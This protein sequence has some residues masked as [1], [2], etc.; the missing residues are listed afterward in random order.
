MRTELLDYDLPEELIAQEPLPERSASRMMVLYRAERRWEHRSFR[1]L[2]GIL[3]QGDCLVLNDTRV[4]PARLL[5]RRQSGGRVEVLLLKPVG[6]LRWQVLARP[7]RRLREGEQIRFSDELSGRVTAVADGGVREIQFECVGRFD[8]IL[9]R[10][11]QPPLPPYIRRPPRHEDR[12]RYQ[13]VYAA[14]PG[15]VAAPTAG[16]HFD[17]HILHELRKHGVMVTT[18]TLHVGLGTFRPISTEL[19]EEHVMHAE[20]YSVPPASADAI[21]R[22]RAAGARV[23]AVGTTVVRTLETVADHSGHISPG[24]GE[25]DLFIYPGY[26]FKAIDAMLTNFHLPRSSLLAMVAAFAGRQFILDAYREAVRLRYRFYSYG[27]CMLIL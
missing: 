21:N 7:A 26:R 14:R 12:E 16:L 3:R 23:V 25:T 1:D 4:L 24:A 22:A 5:G 11:G 6:H 19:V 2:V 9:E 13:T 15:A 17:R 8:D 20:V 10:L 27:D 18:I